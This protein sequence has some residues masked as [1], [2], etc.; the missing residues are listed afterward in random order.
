MWAAAHPRLWR[1]KD[2]ADILHGHLRLF[3][4][5]DTLRKLCNHPDLATSIAAMPDYSNPATP[6]PHLR[7]GKMA[8]MAQ[9]LR[10]WHGAGGAVPR[11]L[12]LASLACPLLSLLLP[13]N[14]LIDARLLCVCVSPRE[15][16]EGTGCSCF[17]RRGKC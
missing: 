9:L 13:A 8:V 10:L 11:V 2:V 7:S 4:G 6:A 14:N 5:I 12:S 16:T 1:A 17:A 15:Q 3:A